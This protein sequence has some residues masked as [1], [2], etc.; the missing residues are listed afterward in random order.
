[1]RMTRIQRIDIFNGKCDPFFRM[2]DYYLSFVLTVALFFLSLFG[3]FLYLF[4]LSLFRKEPIFT[5]SGAIPSVS[6]I[7]PA[8]NEENQIAEKIRNTLDLDW[9]LLEVIVV[10][11]GSTDRT[12]EIILEFGAD[13]KTI[14]LEKRAGKPTA[15][16][17]GA[18][19]AGCDILL[20]T[21]AS[22]LLRRDAIRKMLVPL[23]SGEI[24]IVFGR[25][26]YDKLKYSSLTEGEMFYWNYENILREFQNRTGHIFSV[27]GGLCAMRRGSY[28]EIPQ[29]VISDDLHLAFQ[30]YSRGKRG[31]YISE[32]LGFEENPK[33]TQGEFQRKV[34]VIAGGWQ[35]L[36]KYLRDF[37]NCPG[38]LQFYLQKPLRWCA[39]FFLILHLGFLLSTL[40]NP[41]SF[42]LCLIYLL[43]CDLP[44][45]EWAV[46]FLQ[47]AYTGSI[48]IKIKWFFLPFYFIMINL[49]ALVGFFKGLA[50][51]ESVT[52][53]MEAR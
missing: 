51:S 52:W 16:N 18:A 45:M 20:F 15:L 32:I 1:M 47:Q 3:S 33:S 12:N 31:Y 13:I 39:V 24:G 6:V 4:L 40:E 8:H 17:A 27:I 9:P 43:L 5:D 26:E 2:E 53:K 49:A 21:D 42:N 44:L 37:K 35:F 36:F 19:A 46:R 41:L 28:S 29:G 22:V 50:R 30:S 14:F 23:Q 25:V 48:D 7:I 38:L 10:S 34:R 11:D